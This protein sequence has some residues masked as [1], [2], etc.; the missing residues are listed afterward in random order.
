M[1]V[2][3]SSLPGSLARERTRERL[4]RFCLQQTNAKEHKWI[5]SASAVKERIQ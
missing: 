5:N 2:S 3:N 1:L 4:G